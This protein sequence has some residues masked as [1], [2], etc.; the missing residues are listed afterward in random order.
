MK[1]LSLIQCFLA[2]P[3]VATG[4]ASITGS[5]NQNVSVQAREHTG[6]AV[7]GASCELSNDVGKW[8]I[9][10]P[11]SVG[12]HR[13]NKDLQVSCKKDGLEPG[14]A[15][16][17]SDTKGSMFG[18]ILF[19]GGIGAIVD[20]NNGSAY[21]YPTVIDILMGSFTKIETPKNQSSQQDKSQ[22]DQTNSAARQAT[23]DAPASKI[24][25]APTLISQQKLAA[26]PADTVSVTKPTNETTSQ[27]LRNLQVLRKDEI[28]TEDEFQ[29]KKK[30]LLEQI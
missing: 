3:F 9:T 12:I 28:I 16:V 29:N 30:Q 11:G 10:T 7:V 5:P 27:K 26:V 21:E 22:P 23:A 19:G 24:S 15:A 25:G 13:S 6:V 17:V 2:L 18:N 20:H 4:C 14:R 1:K 8:F